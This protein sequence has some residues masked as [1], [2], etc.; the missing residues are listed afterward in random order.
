M[1]D[2]VLLQATDLRFD[3][4]H[5]GRRHDGAPCFALRGV[6]LSIPHGSIV[7]LLGPNGSGKTTLLRILSGGTRPASGTVHLDG[8]A[9]HSLPRRLLAR[10]V[11]V[12]AQET[13]TAFEYTVLEMVMM[14]RYAWLAAFEVEGSGD[15]QA[16]LDALD[17]TGTAHLAS[18]Q[19]STLSGGEKQRVVIASALAQL[20]DRTSTS[21]RSERA[22]LFLDEPTA[23]LDLHYQLEVAALIGRLHDRRN[24]TIVL[25]THDLRL[26]QALCDSVILLRD[27]AVLAAGPVGDT[28]SASVVARLYAVDESLVAPLL[29]TRP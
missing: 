17:A 16:A 26:V 24:V 28:L 8:E 12:V 10:R 20:D 3:Y 25:S 18:R 4:R 2:S 19:F 23:S 7:G 1:S 14:G 29:V 11:A 27:G 13:H 5:R 22:L 9:L 15:R 21:P 6:S